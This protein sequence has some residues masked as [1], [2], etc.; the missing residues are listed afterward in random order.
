[1]PCVSSAR[2]SAATLQ[3]FCCIDCA[4]TSWLMTA[5][6]KPD[7]VLVVATCFHLRLSSCSFCS[8]TCERYYLGKTLGQMFLVVSWYCSRTHLQKNHRE[9]ITSSSCGSPSV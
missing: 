9:I 1:M 2:E 8:L 5:I 7:L 6:L 4:F 3:L